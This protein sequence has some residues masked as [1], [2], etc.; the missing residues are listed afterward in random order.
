MGSKLIYVDDDE[1]G[2]YRKR[3]GRG[4]VYLDSRQQKLQ[5]IK[6]LERIKS[7]VIPPNWKDVWIC[8]SENGHLQ[9]TGVDEK[10]RKQYIY[11]SDW[12][13][14]R[15]QT[16]FARMAEFAKVLPLIR[17]QTAK[18]IKRKLWDKKK[19]VALVIEI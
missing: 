15:Q 19:V 11:H 1:A 10:G 8:K 5:D 9:A 17:Q 12:T 4:F 16:K 14:F 7:L 13:E 18:D 6:V 2:Y 3:S